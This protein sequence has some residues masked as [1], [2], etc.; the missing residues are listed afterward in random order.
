LYCPE[1]PE[2]ASSKGM[3]EEFM[4]QKRLEDEAI[5]N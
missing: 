4:E 3:D 1:K 2:T 5:Y